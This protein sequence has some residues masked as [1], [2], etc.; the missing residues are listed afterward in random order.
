MSGDKGGRG[1]PLCAPGTRVPRRP[2]WC[3]SG[4]G[5]L[6]SSCSPRFLV[7]GRLVYYL[8]GPVPPTLLD[9]S[10]HRESALHSPSPRSFPYLAVLFLSLSLP[11]LVIVIGRMGI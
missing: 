2:L 10:F 7:T 3:F 9:L 5:I 4:L 1:H 11:E 8:S 6:G